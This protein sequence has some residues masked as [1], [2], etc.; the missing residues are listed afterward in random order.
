MRLEIAM[1]PAPKIVHRMVEGWRGALTTIIDRSCFWKCRERRL[2]KGTR[3][4]EL[5]TVRGGFK[6]NCKQRVAREKKED[7]YK[8]VQLSPQ[9]QLLAGSPQNQGMC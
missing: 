4:Q 5:V 8:I 6:E 9:Y 1:S 7:G 3:G 2:R